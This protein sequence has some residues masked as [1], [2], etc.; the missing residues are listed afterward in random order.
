MLL[1]DLQPES[2]RQLTFWEAAATDQESAGRLMKTLD[3]INARYG[4]DTV[5]YAC[6]GIEK[7]W[8]MRREKMSPEFTTRWPDIPKVKA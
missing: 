2:A 8:E 1:T 6:A 5:Q 3:R 4:K 7:G